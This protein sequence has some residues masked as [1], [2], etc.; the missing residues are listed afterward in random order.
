M[1][2]PHLILLNDYTRIIYVWETRS[3]SKNSNWV[4]HNLVMVKFD[5]VLH[6]TLDYHSTCT[7]HW[8]T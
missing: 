5:I 3:V 8:R 6:V 1:H 2:A 7:L 4:T